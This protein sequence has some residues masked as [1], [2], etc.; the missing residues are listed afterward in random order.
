MALSDGD[1]D[2]ANIDEDPFTYFLTPV[3]SNMNTAERGQFGFDDDEEEEEVDH[4]EDDDSDDRP[5]FLA[6]GGLSR[7]SFFED[8]ME[9]DIDLDL[10][11]GIETPNHPR[12]I[13]RSVSPSSLSDSMD[14]RKPRSG[15]NSGG[16]SPSSLSP[17][18]ASG[19]G[20]PT[21]TSGPAT[22]PDV[23]NDDDG[24]N[25]EDYLRFPGA[26]GVGIG[27]GLALTLSEL[28]GSGTSGKGKPVLVA[29][30]RTPLPSGA[31]AN[32][33]QHHAAPVVSRGRQTRR[34]RGRR[35]AILTGGGGTAAGRFPARQSPPHA[36]REPS[37][38]VWSIEEE[39][40]EHD[41]ELAEQ[42]SGQEEMRIVLPGEDSGA[43]ESSQVEDDVQ[44]EPKDTQGAPDVGPAR[45]VADD[46]SAPP[47]PTADAIEVI[48]GLLAAETAATAAVEDE[49]TRL[50]RFLEKDHARPFGARRATDSALVT[51]KAS[52]KVKK[53]VRFLLPLRQCV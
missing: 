9:L 2:L 16:A 42:P 34:V 17:D 31:R 19:S 10:D 15:R 30:H 5:A 3:P 46:T 51:A 13:V 49:A 43:R 40:D 18:R 23:M 50:V 52:E 35:G 39:E 27:L 45:A 26:G 33:R 29:P 7:T 22:P 21:L 1:L 38:D 36:W 47:T 20:S 44:M 32:S 41:E 8:A 6:P 53:R 25:G 28:R 11:A 48:E 12:D 37:P 14:I 24:S 4:M